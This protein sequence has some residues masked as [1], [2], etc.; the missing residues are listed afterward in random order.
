MQEPSDP[1][2]P[3]VSVPTSSTFTETHWSVLLAILDAVIPSVV[4]GDVTASFGSL[5]LVGGR[6]EEL[7]EELRHGLR[8]PPSFAEFEQYLASRPVADATFVE[9][10]KWSIGLLPPGTR[11]QLQSLL[12]FM[13]TRLGSFIATGYLTPVNQQPTRTRQAIFRSWQNSWFF[14]WPMLAKTFVTVGKA[15]WVLSEPQLKTLNGYPGDSPTS[16]VEPGKTVDFNFMQFDASTEDAIVETDILIIG[17]GCGGGVCAKVLAEAG[18]SVLVVDKG[19]YWRP[20]E[21]PLDASELKYLMEGAGNLSSVDGS[22]AITAGSC[23][24]GGGTVNWSASIQTDDFVRRE[25]A[26]EGLTLFTSQEYQDSLDRVCEFMGVRDL[27]SEQHNH[28]CGVILEGAQ[29]L[30]WKAKSVPQNA[31]PQHRCGSSCG[32]GC[33]QSKKQGPAVSWLPAAAKS[34]A[35]F[36]EGFDVARILLE[37]DGPGHWKTVGAVGQWTSR[38]KK[39]DLRTADGRISRTVRV[40]ANKVILSAGSLNSPLLLLKSGLNNPNIGKHLHMHPVGTLTAVFEEEVKPWEGPILSSA[41][42]EYQ[43]LDGKGHGPRLETLSMF[44]FL[45]MFTLPWRD[46][47]QYKLD[48]LKYRHM[49]CFISLARDRDTGSVSPDPVDG[50]PSVAY[51]PSKFDL[52]QVHVGLVAAAKLAYLRGATELLPAVP[53]VPRFKCGNDSNNNENV[54]GRTLGDADFAAWLKLLEHARLKAHLMPPLMSAHQ[55][56]SCRMS[57]SPAAGVVDP[58]GRVWDTEGL[59]VADASVFP[60]ASGDNPMITNM[61]I[62]DQIARGIA[63]DARM[64]GGGLQ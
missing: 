54:P 57:A 22:T 29:Q 55:M 15:C 1:P 26:A 34:K 38:G 11:Q 48:A 25:W 17:S 35:R 44:P 8:R 30:G 56:G 31:G 49:S 64:A 62:A 5:S 58:K 3:S 7:Y 10:L 12:G 6:V 59:Y 45:A 46:G 19:Y 41:L 52:D 18:H 21:L 43:D 33:R 60:S 51:T 36:I 14:L 50:S 16:P 27:G 32:L 42:T 28:A 13:A 24:G 20:D 53:G 37:E 9:T 23:W 61:A 47:L 2:R 4:G 39:G 40:R 63:K